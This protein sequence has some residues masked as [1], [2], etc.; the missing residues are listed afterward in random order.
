M[1]V[2]IVGKKA[3]HAKCDT[4]IELEQRIQHIKLKMEKT[5]TEV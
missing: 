4:L 1:F 5:S 2:L 3:V